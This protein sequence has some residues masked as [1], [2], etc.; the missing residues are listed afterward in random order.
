[1]FLRHWLSYRLAVILCY[2]L[3]G[4]TAGTLWLKDHREVEADIAAMAKERGQI[5]FQLL[6]LTR[7]WNA[8][9]GG[10]YVKVTPETLPNPYLEHPR[11]DITTTDGMKLT[12]VNPAYMTRQL[13]ELAEQTE[14]SG[15]RFHITSLEPVRPLNGADAWEAESLSQFKAGLTERLSYFDAGKVPVAANPAEPVFRYMAPLL[16]KESCLVCHAKQGYKLG[17]L[18]GGISVTM[19]ADTLRHIAEERKR[20]T[21]MTFGASF[22]LLGVLAHAFVWGFRRYDQEMKR[23]QR[24]QQETIALRT[25]DLAASEA[26]Y[27]TVFDTAAEAIM[28]TDAQNIIVQVN[29]AFSAITLYSAQEALGQE[30]RFLRSGRHDAEYFRD[31]WAALQQ[32]GFWAGEIW[33][34]RKNGEVFVAWLSISRVDALPVDQSH[35]RSATEPVQRGYVATF[36]DITERK[37]VEETMRYQASHDALT[38]LPNRPLFMDRMSNAMALAQRHSRQFALLYVDLDFFKAVN[39]TYGHTAGDHLLEQA[40]ERMR[41]CVREADTVARFGGDEFAVLLSEVSSLDEVLS[42]AERVVT[43]LALPFHL[44][45]HEARVSASVGVALF[46]DHAQTIETLQQC[47]D[48]ALYAVKQGGRNGFRIYTADLKQASSNH[49]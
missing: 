45:T 16:I 6:Q 2:V 22:L 11:R 13:A 24:E 17:D 25:H 29:P 23:I 9:H 5:V 44:G 39:D 10:V 1:M 12:M 43:A 42:V 8:N 14:V 30:P 32:T 31:M 7:L 40:A 37:E 20:T 21:A 18:R 46:P 26:R 41:V 36:I 15:V 28:V 4:L 3:S 34:R 35:A 38:G 19:G 27:R 33:N 47:A 49:D 48:L